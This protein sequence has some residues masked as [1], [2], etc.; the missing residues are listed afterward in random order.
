MAEL[1]DLEVF[2]RILTRKYG[3]K[4]LEKVDIA[5]DKKLNLFECYENIRPEETERRLLSL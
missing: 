5:V 1:P 2:A 4:V 3:G